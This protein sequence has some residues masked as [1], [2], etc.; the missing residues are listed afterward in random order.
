M[1]LLAELRGRRALC[2]VRAPSIPDPVG[3][4]ATLVES[5]LPILEFACT[6]PDA[7]R[8]IERASTVD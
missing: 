1:D 8:L 2:I 6:T 4:A 5:G 3:L 7:P